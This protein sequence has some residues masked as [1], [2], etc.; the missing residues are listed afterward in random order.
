MRSAPFKWELLDPPWALWSGCTKKSR[1]LSKKH[2]DACAIT[3]HVMQGSSSRPVGNLVFVWAERHMEAPH[4][5]SEA[6]IAPFLMI[7]ISC[8]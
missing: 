2:A 8:V 4:K 3:I 1:I 5:R 6:Q 7:S